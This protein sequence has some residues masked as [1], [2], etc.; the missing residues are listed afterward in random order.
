MI[1]IPI[2]NRIKIL[3][4]LKLFYTIC[5]HSKLT[6]RLHTSKQLM[7]DSEDGQELKQK[8]VGTIIN[9]NIVQQV[10]IIFYYCWY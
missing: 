1:K 4:S 9:I 3:K 8:H 2:E 10:G 5:N 6:H 7:C